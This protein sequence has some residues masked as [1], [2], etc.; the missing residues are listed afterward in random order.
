LLFLLQKFVEMLDLKKG[1]HVL[2]VGCG[3]GGSAFLMAEVI[4]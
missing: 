4:T 1:D 3:I 2:D